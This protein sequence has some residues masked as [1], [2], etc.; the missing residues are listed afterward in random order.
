MCLA[1]TDNGI[2]LSRR[3]AK[4]IFNRFYQVDQSLARK[5]G[6]CGLGLSIVK[7]IVEAHG[8]SIEVTSQPGKGSTF[9]VRLP[10]DSEKSKDNRTHA[11]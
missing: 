4:K 8:G 7:F 5:A 1:I 9:T 2:G 3:A 6:G 11:G 10:I